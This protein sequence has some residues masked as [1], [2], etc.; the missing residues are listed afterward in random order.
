[1]LP[2]GLE[3]NGDELR[4]KSAQL[5]KLAAERAEHE[6]RVAE[7]AVELAGTWSGTSGSAVQSAL[8]NYLTQASDVR[9]EEL[10]MS[11]LLSQAI[12]AYEGTDADAAGSLA[13]SM[14]I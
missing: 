11:H 2:M 9:R 12:A 13:Q 8:S 6:R 7:I 14:N 4:K 1:M 10:D 5:S 3:F